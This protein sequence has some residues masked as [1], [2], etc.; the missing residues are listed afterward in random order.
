MKIEEIK[1]EFSKFTDHSDKDFNDLLSELCEHYLEVQGAFSIMEPK[2][3]AS[4]PR[5]WEDFD[6]YIKLL[7]QKIIP[8][9][10]YYDVQ[11]SQESYDKICL[12]YE[13]YFEYKIEL[14]LDKEESFP[15]IYPYLLSIVLVHYYYFYKEEKIRKLTRIP[16]IGR[17]LTR[18]LVGNQH[19]MTIDHLHKNC[20]IK[21]E[22]YVDGKLDQVDHINKNKKYDEFFKGTPEEYRGMWIQM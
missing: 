20:K 21:L 13:Y 10:H 14:I 8:P 7:H 16:F 1:S 2:E 15:F 6:I 19:D 22:K 4:N 12:S 18:I 5:D 11:Y 9:L 3:H 17:M